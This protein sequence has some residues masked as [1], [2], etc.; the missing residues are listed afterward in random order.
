[1]ELTETLAATAAQT[2]PV[3]AI[4]GTIEIVA[5]DRYMHHFYGRM[6]GRERAGLSRKAVRFLMFGALA[7]WLTAGLYLLMILYDM[8]A[9]RDCLRLL[10]GNHAYSMFG[11]EVE[12]AMFWSFALIVLVP[13]V[14]IWIV[15]TQSFQMY[16][17]SLGLGKDQDGGSAERRVGQEPDE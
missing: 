17:R 3:F 2:L 16:V 6:T 14:P 12:N 10:G 13:V 15:N 9:E 1:M 8:R 11:A 7:R 5:I 4:A